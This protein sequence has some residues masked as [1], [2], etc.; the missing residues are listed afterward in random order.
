MIDPTYLDL[1]PLPTDFSAPTDDISA[2]LDAL[3]GRIG[4]LRKGGERDLEA[5]MTFMIRAF[6]EGKLGRWTFDDLEGGGAI[7]SSDQ[8]GDTTS[9]AS[10]MGEVDEALPVLHDPNV[11]NGEEEPHT[12]HS[13]SKDLDEAVSQAV[14]TF[15]ET[16]AT[17]QAR[18]AEGKDLSTSQQRKAATRAKNEVRLA[19]WKA[20]GIGSRTPVQSQRKRTGAH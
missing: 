2:L 12:R 10:S 18:M 16:N 1:L 7:G 13:A 17:T 3:A 15:L 5:A 9:P 4:A 11:D 8:R 14:R 20:K 19:R 6:R